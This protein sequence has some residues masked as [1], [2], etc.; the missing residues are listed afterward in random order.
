MR[1]KYLDL[2]KPLICGL[3]H[4]LIIAKLHTWIEPHY[5]K[6]KIISQTKNNVQE[7][8]MCIVHGGKRCS[9]VPQ[10][11]VLGSVLFDI[12][13]RDLFRL[14]KDTDFTGFADNNTFLWRIILMA[15]LLHSKNLQAKLFS[16][17]LWQSVSL[18]HQQMP[19]D[20]QYRR[21]FFEILVVQSIIKNTTSEKLL[22]IIIYNKLKFDDHKIVLCE[23]A[24]KKL[25]GPAK[26][27]SYI[28]P[29]KNTHQ[30]FSWHETVEEGVKRVQS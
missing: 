25:R 24:M 14:V 1:G 13:L 19:F 7:L 20:C 22:G 23:I 15:W 2:S 30:I 9:R 16:M 28:S 6:S 4:E 8:A 21:Y 18:K 12:F 29:S 11:P 5:I 26:A 3:P 27:E 10:G 17:V